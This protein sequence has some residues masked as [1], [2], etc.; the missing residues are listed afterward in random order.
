MKRSGKDE[1]KG[2]Q[3]AEMDKKGK[4]GRKTNAQSA[5]KSNNR[6][7]NGCPVD[8]RML[9]EGRHDDDVHNVPLQ[10]VDIFTLAFVCISDG[11]Q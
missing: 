7:R 9:G 8:A 10:N 1:L 6:K 2:K 11:T 3:Q 5:N 4:K